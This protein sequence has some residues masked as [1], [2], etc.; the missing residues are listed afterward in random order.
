MGEELNIE[1]RLEQID[2][3]ISMF[4]LNKA[5]MEALHKLMQMDEFKLVLLDGYIAK[6]KQELFD[7]LTSPFTDNA[8]IREALAGQL[9]SIVDLQKYLDKIQKL[10]EAADAEI[11]AL[12]D[13]KREL[14]KEA[15]NE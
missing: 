5:K 7:I 14:E 10:G 6:E 3:E 8:E 12:H 13:L 11:K 9:R 4:E 15:I 1:Q 2:S